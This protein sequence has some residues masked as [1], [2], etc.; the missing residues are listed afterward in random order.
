MYPT[1]PAFSVIW[2]YKSQWSRINEAELVLINLI[3]LLRFQYSRMLQYITATQGVQQV[4]YN[5][6]I[7]N[8]QVVQVLISFQVFKHIP[9]IKV[10]LSILLLKKGVFS[11]LDYYT[12]NQQTSDIKTNKR[13]I[14]TCKIERFCNIQL[15]CVFLFSCTAL[16]RKYIRR[17]FLT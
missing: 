10:F 5:C 16:H 1:N 7:C 4:F 13:F 11:L 2:H 15:F 6:I 3:S 12:L 17:L 14:A 9:S 8:R